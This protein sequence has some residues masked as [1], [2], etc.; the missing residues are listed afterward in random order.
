MKIQRK[1]TLFTCSNEFL[2]YYEIKIKSRRDFDQMRQ[3]IKKKQMRDL[4]LIQVVGR[5]I[6]KKYIAE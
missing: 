4:G 5:G 2:E 1:F 3:M 6:S